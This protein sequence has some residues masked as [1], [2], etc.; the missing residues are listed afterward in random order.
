MKLQVLGSGTIALLQGRGASCHLLQLSSGERILLDSGPGCLERLLA[1]GLR[2]ADIDA[3]VHSHL[4]LD[5][6]ADL[7]PLLFHHRSPHGARRAP[8]LLNGAPGH[9]A[10]LEDVSK[11][12]D[13]KLLSAPHKID[14]TPL[15]G[16]PHP[17][18]SLPLTIQSWPA[19]HPRSARVLRLEGKSPRP[20]SLAYS[21]DTGPCE[22]LIEAARGVDWLL[23]ECTHSER[24]GHKKHLG[25]RDVAE[26]IRQA[27]PRATA[28]VHLGPEWVDIEEAAEAVR[29]RVPGA[30]VLACSDGT[31]L[32]LGR[33]A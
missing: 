21:G 7:F 15:D 8:L 25:P 16:T 12:L 18:G 29:G 13:P 32:S 19:N 6:C 4:H 23:I 1:I 27:K 24:G 2:P 30:E 26:V 11:A 17:L 31:I 33:P 22:A 14:E 3:I 9:R 5:H 10:F 28:L 20:W